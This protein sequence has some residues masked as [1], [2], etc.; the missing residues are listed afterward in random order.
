MI[1]EAWNRTG[2]DKE[3]L[4]FRSKK[5]KIQPRSDVSFE[6]LELLKSVKNVNSLHYH[7]GVDIHTYIDDKFCLAVE[8]KAY[9]ENAMLKRILVDF[10]LLKKMSPELNCCVVQ[11]ETFL[12]GS[13]EPNED[14]HIANSS[15]YTLVSHFPDV[16]L[17]IYTLLAGSRHIKRP[18]HRREFAKPLEVAFVEV[19][20]EGLKA[21]LLKAVKSL[22]NG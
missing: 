6:D 16:D 21:R 3:R 12:G 9:T 13:Y 1:L 11:L 7:L 22:T 5:F 2:H 10:W 4:E 19:V 15:T 14:Y 20:I 18:I 17:G 8:C